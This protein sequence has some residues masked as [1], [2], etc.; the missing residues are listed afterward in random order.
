LSI[1]SIFEVPAVIAAF[2]RLRRLGGNTDKTGKEFIKYEDEL[3][4]FMVTVNNECIKAGMPKHF[5][6]A[7]P[8]ELDKK[9][10]DVADALNNN[11]KKSSPKDFGPKPKL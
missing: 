10:S 7:M 5:G 1:E 3:Y 6:I 4:W 8:E 11:K 2:E 9:H